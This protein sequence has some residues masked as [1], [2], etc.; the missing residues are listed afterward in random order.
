M[1]AA[2]GIDRTLILMRHAKSAWP[3]VPDHDRPLAQR[4]QRD[5]PLMGRWLRAAGHLPDQVMCSTA[6]RA[7]ETWQLTEAG[8]GVSPPVVFDDGVFQVSAAHLLDLIRHVSPEVR[9]LLVIGH[10]PSLPELALSL[11]AATPPVFAGVVRYAAPSAVFYRMRAKF[12]TAAVAIFDFTGHWHQLSP[13]S[14]RLTCFVT[15]REVMRLEVS[16][17]GT[18]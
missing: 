18:S 10:D 1:N 2:A 6:R 7:R 15:P 9:T 16:A 14:G 11:V 5:A 4:G 13:G 3:D 12:P 8:L 17:T